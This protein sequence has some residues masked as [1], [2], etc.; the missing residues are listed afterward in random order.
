MSNAPAPT[1]PRD[2]RAKCMSKPHKG[3]DWHFR[4]D[5]IEITLSLITPDGQA[6]AE[7]TPAQ[8][9]ETFRFPSFS[10][11]TKYLA[12]P[13]GETHLE[14]DLAKREMGEVRSFVDLNTLASGP[15]GIAKLRMKGYRDIAIG[16]GAIV[17]GVGLTVMSYMAAA[18]NPNGGKYWVTYGF[19][20]YG[21]ISA[22]RGV[23]HLNHAAK[24]AKELKEL[25]GQA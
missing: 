20:I 17:L 3:T 11:S 22:G 24:L 12:V 7:F 5:P 23:Y 25:E 21:L 16:L 15:E 19:V 9:A 10:Q 4:L 13:V 1:A 18:S 6:V 2:L 8:A 14:F